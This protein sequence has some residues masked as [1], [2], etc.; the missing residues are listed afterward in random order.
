MHV[1]SSNVYVDIG[2]KLVIEMQ[3]LSTH[4]LYYQC[5]MFPSNVIVCKYIMFPYC[6]YL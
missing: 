3:I 5:N 6:Y 4:C 2:I 1:I